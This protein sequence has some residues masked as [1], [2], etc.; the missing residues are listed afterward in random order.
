MLRGSSQDADTPSPPSVHTCSLL[1]T[2]QLCSAFRSGIPSF[3]E[4]YI[5]GILPCVT[6]GD[7]LSPRS[8]VSWGF[9]PPPLKLPGCGWPLKGSP[10]TCRPSPLTLPAAHTHTFLGERVFTFLGD[11]CS[12]VSLW[13]R[14]VAACLVLREAP[15]FPERLHG[16]AFPVSPG[17]EPSILTALRG[18]LAVLRSLEGRWEGLRGL[19]G[20]TPPFPMPRWCP[21]TPGCLTV[22]TTS[23]VKCPSVFHPFPG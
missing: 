14:A 8:V 7:W 1:P 10:L 5:K 2:W 9:L 4:C 6:F 3:Q 15:D 12:G 17:L 13:G 22:H 18:G 20:L 23:P 21:P 11:E 19:R 16:S